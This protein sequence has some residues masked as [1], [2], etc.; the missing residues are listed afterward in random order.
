M[1]ILLG[2]TFVCKSLQ[3]SKKFYLCGWG[4]LFQVGLLGGR[5]VGLSLDLS[6]A[7][8]GKCIFKIEFFWGVG[9]FCF[10][11]LGDYFVLRGFFFFVKFFFPV[12]WW[13]FIIFV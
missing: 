5:D 9:C 11:F 3:T 4:I 12:L 2:L 7:G 1:N 6:F 8:W 13:S 10:E